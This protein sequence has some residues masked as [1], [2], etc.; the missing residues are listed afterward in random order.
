MLAHRSLESEP[1]RELEPN[2]EARA[3]IEKLSAWLGSVIP[4]AL[5]LEAIR[6]PD[7]SYDSKALDRET[8]Y[9]VICER[10]RSDFDED[11]LER[12]VAEFA[13]YPSTTGFMEDDDWPLRELPLYVCARLAREARSLYALE[14]YTKRLEYMLK[15]PLLGTECEVFSTSQSLAGCYHAPWAEDCVEF[16]AAFADDPATPASRWDSFARP[17]R[18]HGSVPAR[19][20]F[21]TESPRIRKTSRTPLREQR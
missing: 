11:E 19:N 5:A 6:R 17:R 2:A 9:A 10:I 3:R 4:E 12:S 13:I 18:V 8:G 16:L 21:Q 14:L 7:G 20:S 15:H 1:E